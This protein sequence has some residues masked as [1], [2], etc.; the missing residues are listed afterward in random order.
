MEEAKDAAEER[1]GMS[2]SVRM[3]LAESRL[4]IVGL[5]NGLATGGKER[6]VLEI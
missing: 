3:E 2:L 5:C 4:T 6:V 1:G